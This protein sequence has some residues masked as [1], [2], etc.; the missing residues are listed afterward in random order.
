VAEDGFGV[1]S[2]DVREIG[3]DVKELIGEQVDRIVGGLV[4][5]GEMVGAKVALVDG[6]DFELQ[7]LSLSWSVRWFLNWR[8]FQFQVSIHRC[9]G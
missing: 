8:I 7:S 6:Q 4:G 1:A 9:I 2:V 3:V 5:T